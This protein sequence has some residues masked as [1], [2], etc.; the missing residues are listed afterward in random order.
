MS[1]T[2][3]PGVTISSPDSNG[4]WTW[5]RNGIPVVTTPT[6]IDIDNKDPM[7]RELLAAAAYSTVIIVDMSATTFCDVSGMRVLDEIGGMLADGGGELRAVISRP[8]TLRCLA[9]VRYDSQLRI[10][11]SLTEALS[12]PRQDRET[13][14]QAA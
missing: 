12:A 7:R 13:R 2:Q 4:F 10:F 3:R 1:K 9:I 5:T 14:P 6:E 8:F 11:P